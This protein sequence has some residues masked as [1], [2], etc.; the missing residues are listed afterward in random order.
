M[1]NLETET[2]QVVLLAA[3][4]RG[5]DGTLAVSGT[6]VDLAGEGRDLFVLVTVGAT[7][8]ATAVITIEESSDDATFTTITGGSIS[9]GDTGA[10]VV[11]LKPSKRYIRATI[12]LSETDEITSVYNDCAV[13]GIVYNERI[14]PSN[15]A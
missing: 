4:R 11:D 6:S 9:M 12:T 7:A 8:T 10:E 5:D 2:T 3:K 1:R 13:V 14:K 15:V